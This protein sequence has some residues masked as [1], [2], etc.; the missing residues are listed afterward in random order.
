MINLGS[1]RFLVN[2]VLGNMLFV[3][4]LDELDESYGTVRSESVI[5]LIKKG[6]RKW[7]LFY[8]FAGPSLVL[9]ASIWG[10]ML[11]QRVMDLPRIG[12]SAYISVGGMVKEYVY[13]EEAFHGGR[14]RIED[15]DGKE[16]RF[17]DIY[18][19]PY[20]EK[21]DWVK[22]NYWKYSRIGEIAEINGVEHGELTY[23]YSGLILVIMIVLLLSIPMYYFRIFK[24]KP[25]FNWKEDYSIFA[26]QDLLVRVIF[27]LQVI[28]LQGAAVL[29]IAIMGKYPRL[30]DWYWGIL[31]CA[32]YLGLFFLSLLKQKRFV[33][34]KDK[35]Y[36]CSFKQR[37]EGSLESIE[38]VQ[39]GDK[40]VI[41]CTKEEKMEIM[42][43]KE[44][45]LEA[46]IRKIP[47]KH[48]SDISRTF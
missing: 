48:L 26:Y 41:I 32:N 29:A 36:Y 12:A 18:I 9:I 5:N 39:R 1:V 28:R 13:D 16:Y 6:K 23:D 24:W 38:E 19:P 40:G 34:I 21:E 45:Y 27:A 20:L 22:V 2:M 11:F 17:R 10:F 43:T 30:L 37:L 42:C 35:F 4:M 25:F 31:V 33:L 8:T 15:A 14:L 47:G 46:L 3:C 44:Q 7:Y